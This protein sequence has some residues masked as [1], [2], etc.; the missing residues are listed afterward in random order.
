M[1][2]NILTNNFITSKD[3]LKLIQKAII[4]GI[5]ATA[6]QDSI[7][8]AAT[9]IY[10]DVQKIIFDL[11]IELEKRGKIK[12]KE[13]QIILKELQQKSGIEKEKI[14]K[15]LQKEGKTLF[16]SAREIIMTPV[17]VLR[18]ATTTLRQQKLI[19]GKHTS[20][21]KSVKL[22]VNKNKKKKN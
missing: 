22:K 15:K 19:N 3:K 13:T 1:V 6:S 11:L 9:G 4:T 12:A 17:E 14:Y 2:K 20:K 16:K 18:D 21:R 8:K 10:K 7:K 5:G